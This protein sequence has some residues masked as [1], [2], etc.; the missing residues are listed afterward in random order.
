MRSLGI[1]SGFF[2]EGQ[3]FELKGPSLKGPNTFAGWF[4]VLGI[5][6]ISNPTPSDYYTRQTQ[7]MTFPRSTKR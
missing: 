4:L 6:R 1:W 3:G 2:T 7:V 5:M